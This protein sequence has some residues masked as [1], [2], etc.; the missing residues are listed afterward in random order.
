MLSDMAERIWK[1]KYAAEGEYTFEDTVDR[2]IRAWSASPLLPPAFLDALRQDMLDQVAAPNSPQWFNAGRPKN[3]GLTWSIDGMPSEKPILG[4]C[5]IGDI[6]DDMESITNNWTLGARVFAAGAGL[7]ADYGAVRGK[8]EPI[9]AGG[10]SSGLLSFLQV[11]DAIAGSVKSGGKARRA[12]RMITVPIDHPEVLEVCRWKIEEERKAVDMVVGRAAPGERADDARIPI[13][14]R[15]EPLDLDWRGEALRSVSGQNA[16]I[17]ISLDGRAF[18]AALDKGAVWPLVGRV[19]GDILSVPLAKDIWTEICNAAWA[20]GD[21]GVQF[22][23]TINNMAPLPQTYGRI[24]ASNPC[25]EHLHYNNTSCNLA[26]IRLTAFYRGGVFEWEEFKAA[27]RRWTRLLDAT[28]DLAGYPSKEIADKTRALRPIGLGFTDL[29]GLLIAMGYSYDSVSARRFVSAVTRAMTQAAATESEHLG[30]LY[31]V[32]SALRVS[33]NAR[34]YRQQL[35]NIG[36]QTTGTPRNSQLTVIAPTGT[37]GLLM[38]CTTT[39]IEPI[40]SL[41]THKSL[42]GGGYI[43]VPAPAVIRA[44]EECGVTDAWLQAQTASA[45]SWRAHLLMVAAVQKHLSGGISKTINLP[46]S[47]TPAT[48]SDVFRSAWAEGVKSI[49]VYRDGAKLSQPLTVKKNTFLS[50]PIEAGYVICS[51]CGASAMVPNGTCH[52]CEVCGHTTGC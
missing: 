21:P 24:T 23:D 31:G 35:A 9:A 20:N 51:S 10:T 8:G 38:D 43:E 47:A 28:I 16:N 49:T 15:G 44:K 33:E 32:P 2:L 52:V 40:F 13:Y 41:N 27:V 42:D 48:V 11:E 29:G 46:S 12:A 4:A 37:I 18:F 39:G 3:G 36:I 22:I 45:L 30:L 34:F 17:S 1:N 5:F 50:L 19:N 7:G 26:S 14:G 25:S 6:K